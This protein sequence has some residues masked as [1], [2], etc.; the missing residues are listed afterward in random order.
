MDVIPVKAYAASA[1]T[2]GSKF[3]KNN[4]LEVVEKEL[5]G[6][7][8]KILVLG[9]GNVEITNLNTKD[10]TEENIASFKDGILT[11]TQMLFS[12]AETA[13]QTYPELKK[14]ILLRRPP[15]FDPV[16]VD[17]LQLKPQLSKL[18]DAFLFDLWCNSSF[19][20]K[21]FLGDYLMPDP[22]DLDSHLQVY[23]QPD[24]VRYDGLH[25][26]GTSG[27]RIFQECILNTLDKA[28]LIIPKQ[29]STSPE[30]SSSQPT[31][32]PLKMFK[33]RLT[34][35]KQNTTGTAAGHPR[36]SVISPRLQDAPSG[37]PRPSVVGSKLHD[38]PAR[39]HRPSVIGSCSLQDGY[40]LPV[41]NQFDIL[42][43]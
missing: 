24:R 31:Y 18:G 5:E 4:F 12:I 21:I 28:G 11:S 9:G 3:P 43:N 26:H 36:P 2:P 13:L 25:M 7:D 14:V 32:D 6:D 30:T 17:P 40:F 22:R 34:N 10:N 16:A 29:K 8:F 1:D 41:S 37:H 39:H 38:A 23:G 42:G 15:R 20:N 35:Q 33:D 27:R 19:K